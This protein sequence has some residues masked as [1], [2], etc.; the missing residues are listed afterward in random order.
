MRDIDQFQRIYSLDGH[1]KWH[2]SSRFY[3]FWCILDLETLN[4]TKIPVTSLHL[5]K[6]E[7]RKERRNRSMMIITACVCV[8][9]CVLLLYTS[10]LHVQWSFW[11]IHLDSNH[12]HEKNW[13][14]IWNITEMWFHVFFFLIL[15]I[16]RRAIRFVFAPFIVKRKTSRK[17]SS[18]YCT[19][20]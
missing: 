12:E 7:K 15:S 11:S 5:S 16:N 9:H 6:R 2:I 8:C 10:S 20:D 14:F 1:M 3:F 13:S 4:K 19:T 18:I 17:C